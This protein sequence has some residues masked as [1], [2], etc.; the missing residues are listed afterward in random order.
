[1]AIQCIIVD[2][3]PLAIQILEQYSEKIQG[4]SVVSTF[5][6][7]LE[8]FEFLQTSEVDLVF[9]DIQMPLLTGIDIVKSLEKVPGV[10]FTTAFRDYAIEG[11]EL[12]AIDYLLKPITFP[13]FFK[14]VNKFRKIDD[15]IIENAGSDS[16]E[17]E[18][19]YVNE[20]KRFV[21][22]RFKDILY[23]ESLKDYIRI[24]TVQD[25]ILTKEKI[26]DFEE[27][28]PASFLRIHRSFIVNKNRITAFTAKDVEIGEKE[29]PIGGNYKDGVVSALKS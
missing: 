22:V 1:M 8:A 21:K 10:I 25:P 15:Q 7:P 12:E 6:N 5:R 3:E 16:F 29:I 27:K 2:D 17:E 11:F 9:L 4:L 28:L 14:A 20:N 26:S 19:L 13:R 24:N 23:I 18:H